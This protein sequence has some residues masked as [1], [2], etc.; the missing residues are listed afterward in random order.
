MLDYRNSP[1]LTYLL[2]IHSPTTQF[3]AAFS[4]ETQRATDRLI[5]VFMQDVTELSREA[6]IKPGKQRS[7]VRLAAVQKRLSAAEDALKDLLAFYP[8]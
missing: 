8:K 5:R 1:T 4:E 6:S 3:N 7:P 2:A